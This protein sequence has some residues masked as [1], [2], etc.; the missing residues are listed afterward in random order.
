MRKTINILLIIF[1]IVFAFWN[2]QLFLVV[3]FFGGF[4]YYA[5]YDVF[6]AS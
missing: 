6:K 5:S 1:S 4:L 2:F 3:A